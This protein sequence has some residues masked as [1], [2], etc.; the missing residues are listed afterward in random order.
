MN[1]IPEIPQVFIT[2]AVAVWVLTYLIGKNK[3]VKEKLG[4][5]N[6]AL[7]I[8]SIAI[9]SGILTGYFTCDPFEAVVYGIISIYVAQSFYDK[10][11]KTNVGLIN[12]NNK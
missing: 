9:V 10:T 12:G 1:L 4:K 3:I 7:I 6:L 2:V 5:E 8:G 11:V